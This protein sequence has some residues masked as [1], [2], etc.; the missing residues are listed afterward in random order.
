MAPP[1]PGHR[2]NFPNVANYQQLKQKLLRIYAPGPP[3]LPAP[4]SVKVR[5]PVG[6]ALG[7]WVTDSVTLVES[8]QQRKAALQKTISNDRSAP[9]IGGTKLS[10]NTQ[11]SSNGGPREGFGQDVESSDA[12]SGTSVM[13]LTSSIS[14]GDTP[15][16][17][18]L[19]YILAGGI[20]QLK[21]DGE[22]IINT[23][24]TTGK[25]GNRR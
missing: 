11:H 8:I 3:P 7:G 23:G 10:N 19:D 6:K 12:S 17:P 20:P 15:T 1:Q 9:M 5:K 4:P 14:N 2:Y 25:F 13:T 21:P 22:Q 18:E 24:K 16:L